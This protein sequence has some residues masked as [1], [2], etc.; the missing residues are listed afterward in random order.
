M[1]LEK[2]KMIC[3]SE[4]GIIVI[5]LSPMETTVN[6]LVSLNRWFY[7]SYLCI[8]TFIFTKIGSYCTFK[9]CELLKI[10]KS[11]TYFCQSVFSILLN[12]CTD[13]TSFT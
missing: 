12:T 8:C 5:I 1:F 3:K 11:K 2:L 13:V 4:E 9:F 7:F 6:I 10:T